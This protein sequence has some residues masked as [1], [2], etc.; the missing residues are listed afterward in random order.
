MRQGSGKVQQQAGGFDA[1]L[2]LIRAT[3]FDLTELHAEYARGPRPMTYMYLG[4]A[5][6]MT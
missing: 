2:G 5:R 1:I 6:S 3:G 4:C